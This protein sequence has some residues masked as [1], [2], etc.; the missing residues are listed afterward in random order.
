MV[1]DDETKESACTHC[2]TQLVN[3]HLEIPPPSGGG[4]SASVRETS[5]SRWSSSSV[6]NSHYSRKPAVHHSSESTQCIDSTVKVQH[7]R[8]PT[9]YLPDL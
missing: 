2:R 3:L 9:I 4:H 6:A 8:L 5:L 1:I 7:H